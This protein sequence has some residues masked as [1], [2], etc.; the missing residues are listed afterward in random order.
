MFLFKVA[1]TLWGRQAK[2]DEHYFTDQKTE[3]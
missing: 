1:R 2:A 3:P